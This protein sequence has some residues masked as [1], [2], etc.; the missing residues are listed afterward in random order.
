MYLLEIFFI[1]IVLHTQQLGLE[2]THSGS[3]LHIPTQQSGTRE[4]I[5]SSQ[6]V[7]FSVIS[8]LLIGSASNNNSSKVAY[9][10]TLCHYQ[11]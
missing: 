11:L 7:T 6:F 3:W 1:F 2:N 4:W 9:S 8:E 10:L 5:G